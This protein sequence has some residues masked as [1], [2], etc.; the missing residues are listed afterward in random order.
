MSDTPPDRILNL[1]SQERDAILRGNLASL[2]DFADK[3]DSLIRLLE[4]TRTER[5]MI[6]RI[7]QALRQNERLLAAAREGIKSA[8]VR[9][10]ALQSVRDGLSLY[11]AAGDRKTVGRRPDTLEHKA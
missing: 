3:K 11:T 8:H 9:V 4:T 5:S 10:L 1:L 7:D 6:M 2:P